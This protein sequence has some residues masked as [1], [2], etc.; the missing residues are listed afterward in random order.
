MSIHDSSTHL[1]LHA[2]REQEIAERAA[3][4]RLRESLEVRLRESLGAR[5]RSRRG[6]RARVARARR[7]ATI[8]STRRGPRV[9]R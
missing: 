3:E 1:F 5:A 9:A 2:A 8:A 7:W 6:D 4:A